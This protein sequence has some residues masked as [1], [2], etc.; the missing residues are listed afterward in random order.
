MNY[1]RYLTKAFTLIYTLLTT[2]TAGGQEYITKSGTTVF[3]T[4]HAAVLLPSATPQK[5][6]SADSTAGFY[7]IV[8]TPD[9]TLTLHPFVR[10]KSQQGFR[11][12]TLC[13]ASPQR[14]SIRSTLARCHSSHPSTPM[15]VLL[16][17]DVD[18]LPAFSGRH[19][20]AGLNNHSTDLY[21]AE[22]TGD[23]LPEAMVG[24]LSVADT[25]QLARLIAKIIS[26]EQGAF[27]PHYRQLLLVAGD[28]DRYPAPVTT[29]GQVHY[30]S[31]LSALHRPGVDTAC[32]RNPLS[33]ALRDSILTALA[34]NNLLVNYTA[35]CTT[36]GWTKPSFKIADLDSFANPLPTLYFN[37]CC[38]SNAF[39][40]DCLGE[41]LLRQPV[42]G[43]VGVIGATNETLWAE[44]YYWAIGAKYPLTA[45]PPYDSLLGGAFDPAFIPHPGGTT[46]GQMLHQGCRA[47]TLA[48][49]P[50]DA[51]YWEIYTLLGDPSMTPFWIH[52]DTLT[53]TTPDSIA[54]GTTSLTLHATPFSRITATLDTLLLATATAAADSVVTLHLCQAVDADSLAITVA[55]PEAIGTTILLKTFH[56]QCPYLAAIHHRLDDTLLTLRIKNQGLQPAFG[57]SLLIAQ[58]DRRGAILPDT[59]ALVIP[60]LSPLADTLLTLSLG[61]IT[62]GAEPY[63]SAT[64]LL[65]DSNGNTYSAL[66]L[67]L[68]LPD[69]RPTL[70][71]LQVLQPD[72]TPCR[73]LLPGRNYL[74]ALTLSHPA[75]SLNCTIHDLP[76]PTT[77]PCPQT[78]TIPFSTPATLTHLPI[79]VTPHHGLWNHTYT[80]WLTAHQTLE[81]FETADFSNLPWQHPSLYPWTIDS[82]Q[83]LDGRY[84]A[85]SAP[86]HHSQQSTL[87]LD[88]DILADDT[89]AFSYN[90][91]SEPKDWLHF[92]IDGRRRGYWSGNT[93]WQHY[94]YPI[95]AGRHRLEWV[96]IKDDSGSQLDDCARL[97][98][99]RLPLARWTRP[100]GTPWADTTLALPDRG[101]QPTPAG[102]S[103][104]PNPAS[105]R[106][107]VRL[108]P[109]AQPRAITVFDHLG[110]PVDIINIPPHTATTQYSTT[111]LRLGTYTLVLRQRTGLHIQKI[112][113]IR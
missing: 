22:Y 19:A 32:F 21:Y 48:G 51:F 43:A 40:G 72:S 61:G 67:D 69:R 62:P 58:G 44:D 49:S 59:L 73:L 5:S 33:G 111:H 66:N 78:V 83:P 7:Y 106:L 87:A 53:L 13:P 102:F 68:P 12:R 47:V 52:A 6:V 14:D 39:A 100:C 88:I 79:A 84:C 109:S 95:S 98:N 10:W 94:S 103:V 54:A 23:Y 76:Y 50:F 35:H 29:N 3:P 17:G 65:R 80:C 75:D 1:H 20:P 26:Y 110:R 81:P 82:L 113:V 56:P 71:R 34:Q 15:Y 104:Y 11:V 108:D 97:D 8:T 9:L 4:P 112:T 86:L 28:E 18:R 90:L 96:Y 46:L 64:L 41:E 25:A 36:Q 27:A 60:S 2:L 42:G 105:A 38:R 37:N 77:T 74:L 91:S 45:T 89:I 16:V 63:L 55:R 85:R 57:H 93:G 31:R 92:L 99:I 30:L 24:R 70:S 107:T 101:A